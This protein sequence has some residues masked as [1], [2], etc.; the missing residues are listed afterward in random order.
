MNCKS[1]DGM[2][3]TID[4]TKTGIEK[5]RLVTCRANLRLVGDNNQ[6]PRLQADKTHLEFSLHLVAAIC[7]F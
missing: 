2:R 6:T 3:T 4:Q 1:K 7:L 5:K